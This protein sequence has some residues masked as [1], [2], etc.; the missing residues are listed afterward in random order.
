[1]EST[2]SQR[3]VNERVQG[4]SVGANAM[5]SHIMVFLS[6]LEAHNTQQKQITWGNMDDEVNSHPVMRRTDG[7]SND[8]TK[9]ER[10]DDRVSVSQCTALDASIL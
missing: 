6:S 9:F 5:V 8:M 3:C 7:S 4:H 2:N 10:R 1:M